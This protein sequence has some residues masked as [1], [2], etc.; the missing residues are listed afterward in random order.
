M[1][2]M[3][4][5]GKFPTEWFRRYESGCTALRRRERRRIVRREMIFRVDSLFSGASPS[6]LVPVSV[7]G[8]AQLVLGERWETAR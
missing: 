8:V 7:N 6:W 5:N 2:L 3:L 1:Y 4:R